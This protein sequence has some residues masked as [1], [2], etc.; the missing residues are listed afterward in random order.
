MIADGSTIRDGCT[1]HHNRYLGILYTVITRCRRTQYRNHV[2]HTFCI[3]VADKHF[4]IVTAGN[5][6]TFAYERFDKHLII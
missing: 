3:L 1:E 4:H 6:Y 2:I 5:V